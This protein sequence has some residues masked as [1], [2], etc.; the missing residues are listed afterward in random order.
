MTGPLAAS[1]VVPRREGNGVAD[2]SDACPEQG[3]DF[4]I[5][6]WP[7]YWIARVT[8]RYLQE[9]EAALKPIGLDVPRW[10]ALSVLSEFDPASVSEIADHAI[11][12]LSTMTRILQRM[13]EDDL[14]VLRARSSDG[15]VTEASLT[16]RGREAAAAGWQAA[17]RLYRRAFGEAAAPAEVARVMR[18]NKQLRQLFDNLGKRD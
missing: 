12:K 11:V 1:K 14:V 10:R 18:L 6:D 8:G 2:S 4:H 5:S 3:A 7:F 15:R 16:A 13:E 17:D 9:M